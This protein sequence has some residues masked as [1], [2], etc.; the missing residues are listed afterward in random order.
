MIKVWY[1][2]AEKQSNT[3]LIPENVHQILGAYRRFTV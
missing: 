1:Y 2:E 3:T